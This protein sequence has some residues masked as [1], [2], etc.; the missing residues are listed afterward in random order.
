MPLVS[1]FKIVLDTSKITENVHSPLFYREIIEVMFQ[2]YLVAG[3]KGGGGGGSD[4]NRAT[5][6]T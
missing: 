5:V 3:G 1:S 4:K 6:L 2:N